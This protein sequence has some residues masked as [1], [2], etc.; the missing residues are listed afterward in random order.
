MEIPG[1]LTADQVAARLGIK[2]QS[3]YNLANRVADFPKPT[4]VGRT[5]LWLEA[6]VDDWR[7]K[8]PARR[9]RATSSDE[10]TV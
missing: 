1:Y 10:G 4:K 6:A 8:H 5:S 7:A 9:R 2:R 3:V